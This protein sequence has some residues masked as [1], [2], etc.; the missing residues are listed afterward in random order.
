MPVKFI[1]IVESEHV[2]EGLHLIGIK[3]MA[4]DVE[5]SSA[6]GETRTVADRTGRHHDGF[7]NIGGQRFAQRLHSVEHSGVRGSLDR[8]A[9][10]SDCDPVCLGVIGLQPG[11]KFHRSLYPCFRQ[12]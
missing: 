7:G 11:F 4:H 9:L 10:R 3:E 1:D 5:M 8:D 2:D 6:V 12:K